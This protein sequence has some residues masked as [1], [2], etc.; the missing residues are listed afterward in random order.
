MSDS[1]RETKRETKQIESKNY[2]SARLKLKEDAY[3]RP[4]DIKEDIQGYETFIQQL[5][6][7]QK[8]GYIFNDDFKKQIKLLCQQLEKCAEE[9]KIEAVLLSNITAF[10]NR[11][12]ELITTN[13]H[14]VPF[15]DIKKELEKYVYL[16]QKKPLVSKENILKKLR[17]QDK[18]IL[19]TDEELNQQF[20]A[21]RAEAAAYELLKKGTLN[22]VTPHLA[23]C[24]WGVV[25]HLQDANEKLTGGN[26]YQDVLCTLRTKFF[27]KVIDD[28]V[29]ANKVELDR[30][31]MV[32]HVRNVVY[33]FATQE[34]YH[35]RSEMYNKDR[36]ESSTLLTK[37]ILEQAN[38]NFLNYYDLQL[39]ADTF[40]THFQKT[41]W[42]KY[43][44]A[45]QPEAAA[46]WL[47]FYSTVN[48]C[49]DAIFKAWEFDIPVNEMYEYKEEE[50]AENKSAE[51]KASE[52]TFIKPN[53]FFRLLSPALIKQHFLKYCQTTNRYLEATDWIEDKSVFGESSDVR[54]VHPRSAKLSRLAWI[55]R[56]TTIDAPPGFAPPE[57]II[58]AVPFAQLTTAEQMRYF[59]YSM[60]RFG[61]PDRFQLL[62]P[63]PQLFDVL[64]EQKDFAELAKALAVDGQWSHHRGLLTEILQDRPKDFVAMLEHFDLAIRL[65]I[66]D[67][68][69]IRFRWLH[70]RD[71]L[72]KPLHELIAS[73][74][75]LQRHFQT[76][77]EQFMR[78]CHE[79][80][81]D[82]IDL[83]K[84]P[85]RYSVLLKMAEKPTPNDQWVLKVYLQQYYPDA[86]QK[87]ANEEN[88][89]YAKAFLN[90]DR[91]EIT[92]LNSSEKY[93]LRW[94]Q[95]GDLKKLKEMKVTTKEILSN[96]YNCKW[97]HLCQQQEIM[98]YFYQTEFRSIVEVQGSTFGVPL[99]YWAV[100]FNQPKQV[101]M[102]LED[103]ELNINKYCSGGNGTSPLCIASSMGLRNSVK[104]LFEFKSI[105]VNVARNDRVTALY[106][107]AYNGYLDIVRLLLAY[108][109][110][111]DARNSTG[112]TAL[113]VAAENGYLDMARLLLAHG[114]S[115]DAFNNQGATALSIA[116]QNGYLD[117]ARLLIEHGASVDAFNNKGA[118]VL[119]IAAHNGHLEVVRLLLVHRARVDAL[120]NT[121]ETALYYAARNGHLEVVK[122]LLSVGANATLHF[123]HYNEIS[124][125][126]IRQ[127]LFA[128]KAKQTK[129]LLEE[130]PLGEYRFI[131]PTNAKEMGWIEDKKGEVIFFEN[132][133]ADAKLNYFID[134][135]VQTD[136]ADPF[137]LLPLP[138][139]LFDA[140]KDEKDY[141]QLANA[142]QTENQ[143]DKHISSLSAI[144]RER[145]NHFMRIL[146]TV[147]EINAVK[148]IELLQID[149]AWLHPKHAMY[150]L[151][152]HLL[153]QVRDN[154]VKFA[155]NMV[156][157]LQQVETLLTEFQKRHNLD[158]MQLPVSYSNLIFIAKEAKP[159]DQ[160]I[161][162]MY[163]KQYYPVEYRKETAEKTP[164]YAAVFLRVN[165]ELFIGMD[166]QATVL[167]LHI[168]NGRMDA[169]QSMSIKDIFSL[170]NYMHLTQQTDML[171]YFYQKAVADVSRPF[172][173]PSLYWMV[174][175]NQQEKE[176][177]EVARLL[178][179]G[180]LDVSAV[181]D[182]KETPLHRAAA[183][184][185]THWAKRLCEF[186]SIKIDAAAFQQRTPLLYAAGGGRLDMVRLLIE[187]G[188]SV[189]TARDDGTT[190]LYL[191]AAL[192]YLDMVRLLIIQGASVKAV[193]QDGATP[194]FAAIES[195]HL[196]I[197]HLLL[198]HG[199]SIDAVATKG[200]SPLQYAIERNQLTAARF[201][202]A[203]GANANSSVLS[204]N[205]TLLHKAAKLGY[206]DAVM[207]LL[208]YK[209]EINARLPNG[210]TP[211]VTA[212][213]SGHLTVVKRLL[214]A[215]ANPTL[216]VENKSPYKVT[217][218]PQIKKLLLAAEVKCQ[219]DKAKN[220]PGVFFSTLV[221]DVGKL[222]RYL[223]G[224][225]SFAEFK[226]IKSELKKTLKS[227]PW[228][229]YYKEAESLPEIKEAKT[230]SFKAA[231]P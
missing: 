76:Q 206:E 95:E 100:L 170:I 153:E 22:M 190:P 229:D 93:I 197:A 198:L 81:D 11:L 64:K 5:Y 84:I 55:K 43:K 90:A 50:L 56:T 109:A 158:P 4:P 221:H 18:D 211:L 26:T 125:P 106:G 89:D 188:A 101:E 208:E 175:F 45:K 147:G 140:L 35:L 161:F 218:D 48:T 61:F 10:P 163:L 203:H 57:P 151:V 226:K 205:T 212:A 122:L 74:P 159:A 2:L 99:L 20:A 223:E 219:L 224:N 174:V 148:I 169:V 209:A 228:Q 88:P 113:Y 182:D 115:V 126:R 164:D 59:L 9:H 123:D 33:H 19:P 13:P 131:Y 72:Y 27:E 117:M 144:L 107:A 156:T 44:Q 60:V 92:G 204:G 110:S 21:E 42:E 184:G 214:D 34:R 207:L 129:L 196:D 154:D 120:V 62:N 67:L 79:H 40:V 80:P 187:H 171:N 63:S 149:F 28:H 225:M 217:Q 157:H 85:I 116:A 23:L 39:M 70:P 29:E 210:A 162:K 30:L 139:T 104:K 231:G 68:V 1:K 32:V 192:G 137:H 167:R 134:S 78:A 145:P 7:N 227:E 179:S 37:A 91:Q 173:A 189:N 194:F 31:N 186:K 25:G 135:I 185:L 168:I 152:R 193:R 54:I 86:Y 51:T 98:N 15:V 77:Q 38:E 111:V 176:N 165:E 112:A 213:K 103:S 17:E 6:E 47:P 130:R 82:K 181:C 142:L 108:G 191:A 128:A 71:E 58:E 69:G 3:P 114:A 201:L 160:P 199:A 177:K 73:T 66:L 24:D 118:T 180:N 155:A 200:V 97:M 183:F 14:T 121:G 230:A 132:L 53:G 138:F 133:P 136:F 178:S 202:L 8:P 216:M 195:G 215:G 150:Q 16:L 46:E 12:F 222:Q 75:W 141:I 49:I 124:D 166:E 102:L 36:Y 52:P 143:W 96:N 83:E 172:G 87:I 94:V 119:H 41:F 65:K 127:L 105:N 220:M 146:V